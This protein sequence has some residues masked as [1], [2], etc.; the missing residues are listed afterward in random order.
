MG[1]MSQGDEFA[2]AANHKNVS[3]NADMHGWMITANAWLG[4][5]CIS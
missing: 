4:V 5:P 3:D 1:G 2:A